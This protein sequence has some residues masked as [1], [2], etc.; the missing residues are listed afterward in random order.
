M[1][2]G[3][4]QQNVTQQITAGRKQTDFNTMHFKTLRMV[5]TN[6]SIIGRRHNS[7]KGALLIPDLSVWNLQ[8]T[9]L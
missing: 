7:G 5:W 6:K 3:S 2:G 1:G 8:W 4:D 9:E